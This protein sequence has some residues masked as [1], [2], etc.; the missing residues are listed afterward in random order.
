MSEPQSRAEQKERTRRAILDAALRLSADTPLAA[1]SLRTIAGEAGIKPSSFYVHFDSTDAVGLALVE[2]SFESLRAVLGSLRQN[3]GDEGEMI[4]AAMDELVVQARERQD[5]FGFIARERFSG[6]AVVREAVRTQLIRVE[7]DLA[8]DL[9]RLTPGSWPSEDVQLM[10]K[11]IVMTVVQSVGDLI[12]GQLRSPDEV[13]G[14]V[15][16]LLRMQ[17]VGTLNWRPSRSTAD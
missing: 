8:I 16:K 1:I 12:T 13:G 4:R 17:R 10:A 3:V 11:M 6:S 15:T 2:E 7:T 14:Q 5:H 9:A